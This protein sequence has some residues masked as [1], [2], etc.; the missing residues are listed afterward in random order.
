MTASAGGSRAV[1]ASAGGSRAITVSA[2]GSR[3]I[4][5]S[6]GGSRAI[7]VSAG[8]S[9]AVTVSG[10]CHNRYCTNNYQT[11]TFECHRYR[12]IANISLT[13]QQQ[14]TA[15]PTTPT[16]IPPSTHTVAVN[17]SYVNETQ[18]TTSTAAPQGYNCYTGELLNKSNIHKNTTQQA[19]LTS[20]SMLV[21]LQE[22]ILVGLFIA[23]PVINFHLQLMIVRG[24]PSDF[25]ECYGRC[26][27][28]RTSS[29]VA[30]RF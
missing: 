30:I 14:Q 21:A 23:S 24:S 28:L 7:T 22:M 19:K 16:M 12:Y 5:V 3:A 8:G 11:S 25:V 1:T 4:T 9:R 13:F 6:A 18:I 15:P 29:T 20:L 26:S 27:W 2:G 17:M 10:S